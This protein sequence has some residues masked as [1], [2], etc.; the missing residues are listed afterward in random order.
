MAPDDENMLR[1]IAAEA[2]RA[3]AVQAAGNGPGSATAKRMASQN[4]INNLLGP[5]GAP[6]GVSEGW[7]KSLGDALFKSPVG[8]AV[9]LLHA[10]YEPDIQRTLA[11]A[12]LDP[13]AAR[14]VLAAAQKASVKLPPNVLQ[15]LTMTAAGQGAVTAG[16]DAAHAP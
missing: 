7:M 5:L 12:V 1:T 4:V 3:G 10:G 14:A 8:G 9:N 16:E 13:S 11:Q 15:R 6:G 2:D